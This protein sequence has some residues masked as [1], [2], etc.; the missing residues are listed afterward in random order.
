VARE[1]GEGEVNV[2]LEGV[3]GSHAYGLAHAGSD[4][5]TL[6][7]F[8]EEPRRLLGLTRPDDSVVSHEP[9]VTHH[10][11]GKFCSL[12]L[13]CNPTVLELLFLP[14]HTFVT[15]EGRWLL[16]LRG[17]CLSAP[18][19]RNAY[20]GFAEAQRRRLLNKE[21]PETDPRYAKLV[22]HLFRLLWQGTALLETGELVVRLDRPDV[23]LVRQWENEGPEAVSEGA[24]RALARM[25]AAAERSP[26][27]EKP[28]RD[29]IDNFLK[30]VRHDQLCG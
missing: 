6:G 21:H 14:E 19:A 29:T 5:D 11:L 18:L 12:A 30:D 13:K 2:I 23:T 15:D 26:L 7:V 28:D 10:E 24:L 4:V 16:E 9:D 27:P 22:R 8:C 17:R 25:D 3:V 1:E 20:G